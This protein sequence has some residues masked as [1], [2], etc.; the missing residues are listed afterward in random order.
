MDFRIEKDSM[1]E[2]QVPANKYYG[3]QTARSLMNFKIGGE[4]FPREL[5]KAL[6]ILKKAAALTNKELGILPA[7]KTDLIVKASNEVIDGKLDEHFPLVVWQTGSGTQT[8]M[9]ANEVISNRAI[10][11]SG[12]VMGSK[13]PIHPN[14]DVNKAQSSNDT[15]PTA[16]HIAAVEEIHRRLIPMVTKLRDALAAKSKEFKDIIKIGRT[17]LMDA[18][19]L[20]LGQEFSGYTQQ[21]TNGLERI[22]GCMPRLYELAL[23]GTAVGTGLNTH[24]D[25]AVKSAAKIASITGLP[26]ITA[27][28]KFEALATHDALVELSGVLKT[29]AASLM[30]IAN[31]IRWLGSGPRSGIGELNLPENEPGSS[32]MPGKVN[33]TQCEAI[34]MVCAQVFG[35][36]VAVNFGGAM[37]N[38]ELNVFKPVIIYNVLQ[39]IKL[40]A[41]SCES[42]TDHCVV[43]IEANKTNIKKHLENSLMLV[44]ALNPYIGYD[45]AAKVAKKAHKENKTLKEAVVELNLMTAEKFDEVVRPEKMIGPR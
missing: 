44:T 30:K 23:G 2:I 4:R 7:D 6:G 34:T 41:D 27:R 36:D 20:T 31:D 33:P 5:I 14:D 3:A 1:G 24:P 42:F 25:F 37:G 26:F 43:G 8:N 45:N 10:E 39:S 21:L 11:L 16:M 28:N 9:N 35:N 15:F 40:L 29:I 18:T 32:I 19:P 17:H 22:N 13:K 12:G 38:F